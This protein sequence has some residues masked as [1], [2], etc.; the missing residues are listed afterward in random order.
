MLPML[1]IRPPM[2]ALESRSEHPN[3]YR[4]ANQQGIEQFAG[5]AIGLKR[6]SIKSDPVPRQ[7]TIRTNN[8][9]KTKRSAAEARFSLLDDHSNQTRP[10]A[11]NYSSIL[12]TKPSLSALLIR[13]AFSSCASSSTIS[14]S[15]SSS[16]YGLS[17]S[18][19]YTSLI[20][21]SE[22]SFRSN[23]SSTS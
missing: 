3:Q 17:S 8:A 4:K 20:K 2:H 5:L 6:P 22:S 10:R 12:S 11:P 14:T 13:F 15:S 9:T 1:I 23:S 16:S 21:L 18:S 19:S 7:I